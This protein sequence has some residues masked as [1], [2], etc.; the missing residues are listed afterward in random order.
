MR[1]GGRIPA[2]PF[3]GWVNSQLAALGGWA[4]TGGSAEGRGPVQML[5]NRLEVTARSAY[6]W[7]RSLDGDGRPTDSFARDPVEDALERFDPGGGLFASLYP[8]V[9][10]ADEVELEPDIFCEGCRE[11]VTPIDGLCPWCT[12]EP[13]NLRACP[14][15]G[16]WKARDRRVCG[17]CR[18][19]ERAAHR[20]EAA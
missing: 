9:V 12:P 10:V 3:A 6:R 8:E 2:A 11:M 4:V 18:T 15:C 14:G 19:R 1:K 13:G 20:S 7:S 16:G 5:A 17:S